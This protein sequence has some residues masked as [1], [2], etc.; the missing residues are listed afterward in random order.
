MLQCVSE[1]HTI[2]AL[3]N[4]YP[5]G[6]DELDS[7]MFQTVGHHAIDLY[8]DAMGIPLFRKPIVGTALHQAGDYETTDKDEVEDL[9][10]LLREVKEKCDVEAVSVGAILS[11]YQRVRVEHVCLRLGLTP[12]A[13]L[14]RRDQT[15]LLQ[16]MIN[17]GI[18]A[19]LIKSSGTRPNA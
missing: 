16:E 10:D 17:C 1:G 7:Y 8:A 14:W 2:T 15:E 4:L 18:D 9:Y 3:A 12:L 5:V 19:I 11:N 6:K 13:Y